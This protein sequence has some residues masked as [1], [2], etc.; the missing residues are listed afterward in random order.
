MLVLIQVVG[1]FLRS[2]RESS[3]SRFVLL[4]KKNRAF[5]CTC[6]KKALPLRPQRF[7]G[8]FR[9]DGESLYLLNL[10]ARFF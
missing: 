2:I 9:E 1:D 8:T 7:L 5:P 6:Q 4:L 3:G 10:N